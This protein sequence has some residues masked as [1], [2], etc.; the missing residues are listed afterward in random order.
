MY[1]RSTHLTEEIILSRTDASSW[2]SSTSL[3]IS[4]LNFKLPTQSRSELTSSSGSCEMTSWD[5]LSWWS[6]LLIASHLRTQLRLSLPH[7]PRVN[8]EQVI[9]QFHLNHLVVQSIFVGP[10][11]RSS[12]KGFSR[13]FT[14]C[15]PIGHSNVSGHCGIA[16]VF[17]LLFH[18]LLGY[19]L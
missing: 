15:L 19:A 10:G 17:N 2:S 8:R 18:H 16:Q 9:P 11:S 7:W 1:I 4:P 13:Q 3:Q 14:F 6:D 5:C 12:S